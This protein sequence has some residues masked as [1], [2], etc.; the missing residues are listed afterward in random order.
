MRGCPNA[1]LKP[2]FTSKGGGGEAAAPFG[3]KYL[4]E[5]A[6]GHPLKLGAAPGRH[7][8]RGGPL[9]VP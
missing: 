6:L 1:P 7:P 2:I 9:G 8:V 3:C 4:F 5:G